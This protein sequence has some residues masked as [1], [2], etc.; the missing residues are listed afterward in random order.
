MATDYKLGY[1]FRAAQSHR[2]YYTSQKKRVI[3]SM[4]ESDEEVQ[5][6]E[7]GER[8]TA[9]KTTEE[10]P[11]KDL[12]PAKDSPREPRYLCAAL[13]ITQPPFLAYIFKFSSQSK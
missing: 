3:I 11:E 13:S 5:E 6:A 10:G 8:R 2:L 4:E 7:G 9:M 12:D 1:F